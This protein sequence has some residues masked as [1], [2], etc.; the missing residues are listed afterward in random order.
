MS[1]S[2]PFLLA[3]LGAALLGATFFAVQNARNDSSEPVAPAAQQQAPAEPQ[4]QTPSEPA[5][6]MSAED[7][8]AAAFAGDQ[9]VESGK[10]AFRLSTEDFKGKGAR[11]LNDVSVAMTGAF[12]GEGAKEM[13][14]FDMDLEIAAAGQKQTV[15]AISLGDRGYV[16][17]GNRA[18]PVPAGIMSTL[19]EGR[20][21]IADYAGEPQPKLSVAGFDVGGWLSEPKVA[22]TEQMDGVEVT[23]VEATLDPSRFVDG[24]KA[25]GQ[26]S[27]IP[28][29]NFLDQAAAN[30]GV[31]EKVLGKPEVDI[32]VGEDR[33]L[34]RMT[35]A[36]D[37]NLAAA[38]AAADGLR[39]GRVVLDA[40][41]SE[42][43]KPQ[44]ISEP[45][46]PSHK[47]IQRT[48]G[49]SEALN[50][51]GVLS[52][53][54]L[55][56]QQPGLAGAR[57]GNIEIAEQTRGSAP[58]TD[59]P[60]RAARAVRAGKKVVI[61]FVNP[62]GLDD[63]AVA[64]TAAAVSKRTKAVV[65]V[66]HVD[67]VDRYGKLVEDLGVSQ[68]PSVVLVDRTGKARLIEGYV[69]TDTLAQA[70]ADAR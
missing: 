40:R 30:R 24:L 39:G 6:G 13:P 58:L 45:K 65:L 18:Y 49:R 2:R 46:N 59:N 50:S 33:I 47:S 60:Q 11:Q 14:L 12:Q 4:A 52:L 16:T 42:V 54:A 64:H 32:Y 66:D 26:G 23:H 62:E 37:L 15:G 41:L 67:A 38:G 36:A 57:A 28:E 10:F 31:I 51:A 3:L 34:R 8:L 44:Q 20:G 70:V 69:D 48:F 61:L 7:A 17:R 21:Q 35:V 25:L 1:I 56:V 9:K 27:S 5:S 43:N 63:R 19:A 29:G 22:G 55:M 68:T 53:G